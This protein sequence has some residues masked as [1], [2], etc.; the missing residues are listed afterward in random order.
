MVT[1]DPA[2]NVR[3]IK[4]QIALGI[5]E[6]EQGAY[7]QQAD[8]DALMELLG[9]IRGR[10]ERRIDGLPDDTTLRAHLARLPGSTVH[11]LLVSEPWDTGNVGGEEVDVDWLLDA[12]AS[13]EMA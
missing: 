9:R 13:R 6:G 1:T 11:T 3:A 8:L 7:D 4:D 2:G 10:L 12:P 5:A